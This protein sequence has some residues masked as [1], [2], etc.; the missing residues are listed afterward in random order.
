[1]KQEI[2]SIHK[3]LQTTNK[4]VLAIQIKSKYYQFGIKRPSVNQK[5]VTI[6]NICQILTKLEFSPDNIEKLYNTLYHW[7]QDRLWVIKLLMI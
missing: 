5:I 7:V 2:T 1:M 3:D 6:N 4:N